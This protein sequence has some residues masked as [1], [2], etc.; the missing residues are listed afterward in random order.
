MDEKTLTIGIDSLDVIK[1]RTNQILK[2]R[3]RG[4]T[5]R[6]S[7]LS[8]ND[9]K[10]TLTAD[11]LKLLRALAGDCPQEVI[12]IARKLEQDMDSTLSDAKALV[13]CGLLYEG[14]DGRFL[15]PYQNIRLEFD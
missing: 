10:K 13:L 1:N 8:I 7:F 12:N 2:G 15:F 6:Y 14:S 9:L 4:N 11:R 3:G 5:P